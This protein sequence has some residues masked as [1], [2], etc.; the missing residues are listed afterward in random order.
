MCIYYGADMSLEMIIYWYSS[1]GS[2]I[3]IDCSRLSSLVNPK[4]VRRLIDVIGGV[5]HCRGRGFNWITSIP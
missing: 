2:W 3:R 5:V 4:L 1:S